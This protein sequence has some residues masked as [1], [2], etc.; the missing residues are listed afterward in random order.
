MELGQECANVVDELSHI[1]CMV[2]LEPKLKHL[3]ETNLVPR[4][5]SILYRTAM[6]ETSTRNFMHVAS[7]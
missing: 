7:S 4:Y 5:L 6:I 2:T 3:R 1:P